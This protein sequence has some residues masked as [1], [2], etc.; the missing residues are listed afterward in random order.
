MTIDSELGYARCKACDKRFYPRWLERFKVFTDLC[1]RCKPKS[2]K[3]IRDA[4]ETNNLLAKIVTDYD[5]GVH[6]DLALEDEYTEYGTDALGKINL[7][8][9]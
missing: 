9:R 6:G 2:D 5:T 3:A 8:D 1:Y 4:E 7:F